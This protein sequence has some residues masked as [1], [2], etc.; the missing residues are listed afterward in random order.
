M[1]HTRTVI[2]V[3]LDVSF[4]L[5]L[6]EPDEQDEQDMRLDYILDALGEF[7]EDEVYARDIEIDVAAV[8][9]VYA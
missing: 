9:P 1:T 5:E 8:G 2:E 6:D 3:S 7:L 4:T